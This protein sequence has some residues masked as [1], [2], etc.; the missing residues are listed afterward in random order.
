MEDWLRLVSKYPG[1]T[2]RESAR[3]TFGSS[4][5]GWVLPDWAN[6]ASDFDGVHI[7]VMAYLTSAYTPYALGSS[8]TI[9]AGWNPD[10][11]LWLNPV[12]RLA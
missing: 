10:E 12:V 9:L 6:V 7:S 11:T 1:A 5:G 3:D 4:P 2:I 8:S